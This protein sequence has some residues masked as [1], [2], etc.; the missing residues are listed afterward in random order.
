MARSTH[1]TRAHDTYEGIRADILAGRLAPGER[2]KFP[3]LCRRYGVG[4]GV[5]REAL[6]RLVEQDLIRSQPHL[7]F[8]VVPLSADDLTELTAARVEIE[9]LVFRHSIEEGDVA[10]E[11]DLVA[12]HHTLERTQ[13]YDASDPTRVSDAWSAAHTAFHNAL[14]NGCRNTRLRC[15]AISMRDAA[16]L[17]RAWS[18]Q[19]E[20]KSHRDVV[21]EHRNLMELA[22][23]RDIDAAVNAL[24][25][26]ITRTTDVLLRR[27]APGLSDLI[28]SPAEEP[29]A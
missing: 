16:E 11:S 9:G 6:T 7:G 15:V 20:R 17:Y 14:L 4:V 23:A 25:D 27:P 21:G 19:P 1:G 2:L 28:A 24:A 3:E 29:V 10:W 5:V 18:Q 8:Q 12:K 13:Q 22:L 26:H